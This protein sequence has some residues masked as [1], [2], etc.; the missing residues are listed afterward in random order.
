MGLPSKLVTVLS[1]VQMLFVTIGFLL[2]RA[3]LNF[4]QKAWGYGGHLAEKTHRWLRKERE[5][6]LQHWGAGR[7]IFT[8]MVAEE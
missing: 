6:D 2:T 1:L 7:K 4:Y 3:I 8:M 5:N